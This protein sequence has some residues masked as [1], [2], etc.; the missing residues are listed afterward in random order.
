MWTYWRTRNGSTRIK[1][2]IARSIPYFFEDLRGG[3][4]HQ[5]SNLLRFT[6]IHANMKRLG[7]KLGIVKAP[8]NTIPY[9]SDESPIQ[10]LATPVSKPIIF[11]S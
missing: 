4:I 5:V 8:E 3:L 6:G 2:A 11:A 1:L 10:Q 9:I 7:M